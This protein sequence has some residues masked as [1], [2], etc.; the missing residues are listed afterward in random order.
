M[1]EMGAPFYNWEN[2]G[3][4]RLSNLTPVT[5]PEGNISRTKTRAL[6]F[7]R[8]DM[9]NYRENDLQYNK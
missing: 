7:Q 8:P 5:Q 3:L 9:I 2:G 1:E 6:W 4:E